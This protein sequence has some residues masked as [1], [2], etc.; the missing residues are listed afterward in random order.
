ML[1][2]LIL[3][4]IFWDVTK[5]LSSTLCKDT[6]CYK[7]FQEELFSWHDVWLRNKAS[8]YTGK[9]QLKDKE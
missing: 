4:Y 2:Q 5:E 9:A 1:I 8:V 3:I 7:Y 6:R